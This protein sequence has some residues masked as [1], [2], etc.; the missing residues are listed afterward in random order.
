[1]ELLLYI[2]V[3][4]SRLGGKICS[5]LYLNSESQWKSEAILN[6]SGLT[7]SCWCFL[8]VLIEGSCMRRKSTVLFQIMTDS[9]AFVYPKPRRDDAAMDE[10]HGTKVNTR[11]CPI[12]LNQIFRWQTHTNG[13][14]IQTALKRRNL[15]PNKMLSPNP[16][17]TL[18]R[19]RHELGYVC[20]LSTF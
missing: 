12:P 20:S 6:R 11:C 18:A 9:A 14:R 1:M 7:L 8:L 4:T 19:F 17:S 10:Y 16:T 2:C 15:W 3:H 5:K 13:W